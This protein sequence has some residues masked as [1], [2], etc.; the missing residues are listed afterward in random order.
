MNGAPFRSATATNDLQPIV[1]V[2]D[3][4]PSMQFEH[5]RFGNPSK[6][7]KYLDAFGRPSGMSPASITSTTAET[8]KKKRSRHSPTAGCLRMTVLGAPEASP[9]R[10]PS[11]GCRRSSLD[12]M[13]QSSCWRERKPQ[14][15]VERFGQS[16]L[17]PP[18]C[19]VPSHHIKRIGPSL[20]AEMCWF[21]PNMTKLVGPSPPVLPRCVTRL[22]PMKSMSFKSLRTSRDTSRGG[23]LGPALH[24]RISGA[25]RAPHPRAFGPRSRPARGPA[26][27]CMDS[28]TSGGDR[29]QGSENSPNELVWP[30]LAAD[31]A[32]QD[33][34]KVI[35]ARPSR[36]H[37]LTESHYGPSWRVPE[38]NQRP[39]SNSETIQPPDWRSHRFSP[40]A[41]IVYAEEFDGS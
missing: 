30:H 10:A 36:P 2:P 11:T 21:P 41:T 20:R 6:T 27:R 5:P 38:S 1:P 26:K 35:D 8:R 3:N 19:M 17:L 15:L 25:S 13:C 16:S 39:A 34:R 33:A 24:R 18:P 7:W 31:R 22:G 9:S 29:I 4:A 12:Q 23:S 28:R 32:V 14:T 37:T 40:N